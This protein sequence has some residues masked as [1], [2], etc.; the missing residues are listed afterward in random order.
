[1]AKITLDRKIAVLN[2]I[3]DSNI[4]RRHR[5]TA[6]GKYAGAGGQEKYK[7]ELDKY[8]KAEKKLNKLLDKKYPNR[9]NP[10][11]NLR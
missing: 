4:E 6:K 2:R 11:K 8:S 7:K 5:D 10:L 3:T 1:M 9:Y